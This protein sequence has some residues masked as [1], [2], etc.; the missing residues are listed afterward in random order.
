MAVTRYSFRFPE[1][2]AEVEKGADTAVSVLVEHGGSAP[3][4]SSA[5]LTAYDSEGATVLSAVVATVSG[6]EASYTIPAATTSSLL[7]S[8]GWRFIWSVTIGGTVYTARNSGALV[9]Y[10]YQGA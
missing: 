9:K 10:P 1:G 2:P 4:I 6:G 3:T 8:S 7:L 5:T